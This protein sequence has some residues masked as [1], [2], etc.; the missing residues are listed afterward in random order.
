MDFLYQSDEFYT[1]QEF[2]KLA[3]D[4]GI[5]ENELIDSAS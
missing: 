5:N 1:Q 2:N 3:E 4:L